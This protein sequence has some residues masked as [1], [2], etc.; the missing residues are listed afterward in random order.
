MAPSLALALESNRADV[1]RPFRFFFFSEVA[2]VAVTVGAPPPPP[3]SAVA[4]DVSGAVTSPAAAAAAV[5]RC[6]VVWWTSLDLASV[7]RRLE[8]LDARGAPSSPVTVEE[9]SAT[10]SAPYW[11]RTRVDAVVSVWLSS[12]APPPPPPPPAPFPRS[13]RSVLGSCRPGT[14][15]AGWPC[16]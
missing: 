12:S 1:T 2:T 7:V 5:A 16:C 3:S 10:E 14:L 8:V 9:V 4:F 13:L 6:P 11:E 15:L